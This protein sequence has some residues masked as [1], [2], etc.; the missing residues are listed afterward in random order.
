MTSELPSIEDDIVLAPYILI[1]PLSTIVAFI[2]IAI[3]FQEA[4]VFGFIMYIFLVVGQGISSKL[5]VKWKY[6]EGMF[7]DKRVSLISE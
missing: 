2:F 1:S 7:S 6:F 3:N 4:A 5:T